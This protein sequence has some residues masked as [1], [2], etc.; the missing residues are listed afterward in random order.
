MADKNDQQQKLRTFMELLPLT[1]AMA[2]LGR[3]EAG[4]HLTE[5]QMESRALSIKQAYEIARRTVR[6]I[7]ES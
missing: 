2:G 3:V 5:D 4:R 6:E 1:L 7:I